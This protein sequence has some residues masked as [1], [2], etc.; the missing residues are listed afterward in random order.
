MRIRGL[1]AV[2]ICGLGGCS[3]APEARPHMGKPGANAPKLTV[4]DIGRNAFGSSF[5]SARKQG[6]TVEYE[7]SV[8]SDGTPAEK[9]R[10]SVLLASTAIP[11]TNRNEP[12]VSSIRFTAVDPKATGRKLAVFTIDR[13]KAKAIG[14]HGSVEV[15]L[16]L[17][18]VEFADPEYKA[19]TVARSS[20]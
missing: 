10:R 11:T 9:F 14:G 17:I 15:L 20:R 2:L 12:N 4:E 19:A 18:K 5:R 13:E 7:F 8:P 1:L 16:S 3:Q 6:D